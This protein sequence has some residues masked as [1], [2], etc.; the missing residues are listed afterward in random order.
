MT[1]SFNGSMASFIIPIV[2][3]ALSAIG[4]FVILNIILQSTSKLG[5]TH[6]RI[7]ASM[8][9]FDIIASICM[10]LS[11]L[12]MPSD[13]AFRNGRPMW[14]NKTTCQ[15]QGF[16]IVLG[17]SGGAFLYSCLAWYMV[18]KITFR[19]DDYKIGRKIEPYIMIVAIALALSGTI[20]FLEQDLINA[21]SFNSFCSVAPY[22]EDCNAVSS[23]AWYDCVSGD[24]RTMKAYERSLIIMTI[25]ITI[26]VIL[27]V[28]AMFL[29]IKTVCDEQKKIKMK[30]NQISDTN[31]PR[32]NV[33]FSS[34]D[35]ST[36]D[37]HEHQQNNS[38]DLK[39]SRVL[40]L[41]A[42]MYIM[43][44][45]ITWIFTILCMVIGNGYSFFLDMSKAVSLPLQGFWNMIIFVYDKAYL[46]RQVD[47]SKSWR[48]AVKKVLF[49][50]KEIP[51]A[52]LTNLAIIE[53]TTRNA[54]DP[55]LSQVSKDRE[56]V[57]RSSQEI[58]MSFLMNLTKVEESR[59][60]GNV[61]PSKVPKGPTVDDLIA[62]YSVEDERNLG[63]S[64]Q[65]I[66]NENESSLVPSEFRSL[67]DLFHNDRRNQT[68]S[69]VQEGTISVVVPE[70]NKD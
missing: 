4:S 69:E 54:G 50:P 1:A 27:I 52:F 31:S 48:Q 34:E 29:I 42:L 16:L 47:P 65:S 11:T 58:T 18:C 56:E 30:K 51:V 68:L 46:V 63:F 44:F 66:D 5:T 9:V 55:E 36:S 19:M 12:P 14:G 64:L 17:I 39:Y 70:R 53:E 59:N 28:I 67:E 38:T 62:N 21:S 25:V 57:L 6:H 43:A 60:H 7:M 35:D 20:F 45:F 8:S 2:T 41:Q 23:D 37:N 32:A 22:S 33:I 10:A 24:G 61:E 40:I 49:C 3:G 26:A 13:T 15:I